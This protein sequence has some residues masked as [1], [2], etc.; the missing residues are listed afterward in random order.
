LAAA[1]LDLLKHDQPAAAELLLREC[2]EIRTKSQP[3]DWSTFN[4]K[5]LLGGSLLGQKQYA[6]A[7][8]LLGE[9]YEGMKDREKTMPEIAKPRM[10]EAIERLVQLYNATDKK[11]KADEWRK[12][13]DQAKAASKP[14]IKP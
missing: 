9:G 3:D 11:D 4:T 6:E 7:E 14:A 5:S 1:G 2:L 8:P 10:T 13:L 12:K